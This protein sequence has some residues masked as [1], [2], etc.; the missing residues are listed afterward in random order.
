MRD[1]P[2]AKTTLSSRLQLRIPGIDD[3]DVF[4]TAEGSRQDANWGATAGDWARGRVRFIDCG[5]D[6]VRLLLF[7]E[8]QRELSNLSILCA[9]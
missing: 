1:Q 7:P 8:Q 4:G 2:R 6:G 9:Q 3:Q 5:L